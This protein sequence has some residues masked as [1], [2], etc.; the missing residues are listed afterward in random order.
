M[1]WINVI[2]TQSIPLYLVSAGFSSSIVESVGILEEYY[3][4]E[5]KENEKWY[6]LNINK[7]DNLKIISNIEIY[8]E[9]ETITGFQKPIVTS[10]NKETVLTYD[11]F[12]ELRKN[13]IVMGDLIDD[14]KMVN[15][16]QHDNV[17]KIGFCNLPGL[18]N[19]NLDDYCENFDIVITNDGSLLHLAKIISFLTDLEED[20]ILNYEELSQNNRDLIQSILK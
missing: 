12:P 13:A 9:K 19:S 14:L 15:S 4:I 18:E 11:N 17:L 10:M 6:R 3:P 16:L 1:D 7:I 20:L 8:D 5:N 2:N